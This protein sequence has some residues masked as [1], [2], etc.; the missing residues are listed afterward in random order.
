MAYEIRLIDPNGYTAAG[1]VAYGVP[2]SQV[3]A[4]ITELAANAAEHAAE[5]PGYTACDYRVSV[6]DESNPDRPA[7]K[8]P[9]V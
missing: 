6:T 9:A 2:Q 3:P 1:H 5:W 4:T 8:Y 7:V